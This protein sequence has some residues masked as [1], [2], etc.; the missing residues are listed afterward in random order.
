MDLFSQAEHD[1]Q[2]QAILIAPDA[3]YLDAVEQAIARLLPTM[4]RE[5]ISRA[6]LSNRGALIE[7]PNLAAAVEAQQSAGPRA[8]GVG[9]W[10]MPRAWIDSLYRCRRYFCGRRKPVK[11]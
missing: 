10:K 1:E 2:A 3:D 8:S 7:V 5:S 4:E 6:S 9:Q 11:P